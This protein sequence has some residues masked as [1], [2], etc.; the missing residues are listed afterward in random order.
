MSCKT[1]E[2]ENYEERRTLHDDKHKNHFDHLQL[3]MQR[4]RTRINS[5]PTV[6][7]I[8]G[9]GSINHEELPN[10]TKPINF[11]SISLNHSTVPCNKK[12]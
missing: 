7:I 1:C 3:H 8:N 9:K 2:A 10:T 4:E 12:I 5:G 6:K 11:H